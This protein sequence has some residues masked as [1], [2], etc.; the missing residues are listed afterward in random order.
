MINRPTYS[1][2]P[3]KE[4]REKTLLGLRFEND[5]VLENRINYSYMNG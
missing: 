2:P 4:L 3:V 5:G 1:S